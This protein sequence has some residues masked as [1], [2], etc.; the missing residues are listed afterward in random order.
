MSRKVDESVNIFGAGVMIKHL[1][2]LE[3]EIEGVREARDIEY[4][5]RMRVASRRL[6]S[7]L[8][9]FWDRMPPKKR[10]RWLEQVRSITRALGAARDLDVQIES[11]EKILGDLPDQAYRP[12]IERLLLRHRQRRARLQD[13]V[14]HSLD[15]LA[16]S[17]VLSDIR[18]KLASRLGRPEQVYLFTPALYQLS[19]NALAAKLDAFLAYEPFIAQPEHIAEL[20]AMRIAAKHLRYTLEAMAPLYGDDIK[21]AMQTLRSAQ[22]L[23]GEIH[24]CDVWILYLPG[25]IEKE[26]LRTLKYYGHMRLF[27]RL[28]TGLIYFQARVQEHRVVAYQKFIAD[29]NESK[30]MEIWARFHQVIQAPFNQS[31]VHPSAEKT[32][33]AEL[34]AGNVTDGNHEVVPTTSPSIP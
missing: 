9:L 24:D 27:G 33:T 26:R 15:S 32:A 28:N 12:G 16:A 31:H 14:A 2:A 8:D 11:I 30:E 23:L 6:R 19:F 1:D 21:A 34:T 5:H 17:S 22:E 20:H 25:F 29:W 4:I 7:A 10:D 13:A 3:L 18:Q